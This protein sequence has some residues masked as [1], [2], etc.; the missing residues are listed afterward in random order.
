MPGLPKENPEPDAPNDGVELDVVVV[1]ALPK[2]LP[3]CVPLGCAA[4]LPNRLVV[5]AVAPPNKPP[6]EDEAPVVGVK[7]KGLFAWSAILTS[8][9]KDAGKSKGARWISA[10]IVESVGTA[11]IHKDLEMYQKLQEHANVVVVMVHASQ[12]LL[13]V[14][15]NSIEMVKPISLGRCSLQVVLARFCLLPLLASVLNTASLTIS[16]STVNACA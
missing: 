1:F 3:D 5:P 2:R 6:P 4:L 9:A 8:Y 10:S 14:D 16:S 11:A 13:L 7:L 12:K 15:M